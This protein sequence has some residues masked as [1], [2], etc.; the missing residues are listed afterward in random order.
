MKKLSFMLVLASI[1]ALPG[2]FSIAALIGQP[3]IYGLGVPPCM[4][5][6][7]IPYSKAL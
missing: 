5:F 2:T 7:I 4:F 1:V 3:E 6:L